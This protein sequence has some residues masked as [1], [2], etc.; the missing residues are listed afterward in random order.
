LRSRN[1]SIRQWI[2]LILIRRSGGGHEFTLQ[3]FG[4]YR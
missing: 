4:Y 3:D 2:F 1:C